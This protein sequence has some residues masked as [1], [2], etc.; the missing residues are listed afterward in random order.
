MQRTAGTMP[1][2][3]ESSAV[4]SDDTLA[5]GPELRRKAMLGCDA[6]ESRSINSSILSVVPLTSSLIAS[7]SD[8]VDDATLGTDVVVDVVTSLTNGK[9]G[10]CVTSTPVRIAKGE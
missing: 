1:K 3:T 6:F 10:L 4:C 2:T 5:S 8:A 9:V 7:R